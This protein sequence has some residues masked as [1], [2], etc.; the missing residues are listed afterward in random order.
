MM[1]EALLC[2]EQISADALTRTKAEGSRA[3][4][5]IQGRRR[6]SAE[7]V[8]PNALCSATCININLFSVLIVDETFAA[9]KLN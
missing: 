1:G 5:L 7:G 4:T 6:G 8:R 2:R 9:I 3:A